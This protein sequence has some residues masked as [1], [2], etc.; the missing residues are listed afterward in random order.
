MVVKVMMVIIM[1]RVIMKIKKQSFADV[2]PSRSFK[3]FA[4]FTE[5]QLCW[6]FFLIKL[7]ALRLQHRCFHMKFAN[8]SRTPFLHNTS[9][10][11]F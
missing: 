2:L 10:G 9:G 8:F 5:M 4:N 3:M 1:T 6:S 11:C 7:Q